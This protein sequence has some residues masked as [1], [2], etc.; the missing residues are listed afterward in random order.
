M[1][2][3]D[4]EKYSR[5]ILFDEV[6][7]QG[8]QRLLESRAVIVGCGALGSF[9]ATALARAG[10]GNMVIIDRDYVEPSNLQRQWL[11]DESDAEQ[12]LPKAAAAARRLAAINSSVQV[13]PCI[14]DLTAAN[15]ERL[16]LPADVILDGCDNFETRYLINDLA[17]KHGI[18]WIYGAAV[19]SYGITMP[20][21]PKRSACL[22]CIFPEPPGGVQPTCDTAGILNSITAAIAALQV[23]DALKIMAGKTDAVQARMLTMDV[24]KGTVRTVSC[25]RADPDC[26][27]CGRRKFQYLAGSRRR[28]ATLC[29]R[30]AVQINERE[31]PLDLAELQATL[32]PL[33]TVRAN[34]YALRF[35]CP[36]HEMTIFADGRAIVKGTDDIGVARGLYARYVGI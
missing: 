20:I 22:A 3:S 12:A 14:A 1:T 24:W 9:H 16:L 35:I 32:E 34:D 30:D 10:V 8:Q 27:V 19:G 21:L 36:P 7:E 28:A 23:A 26:A 17:V 5:Q 4:R 2:D 33:G 18:P 29:G 11:F 25:E 31:R 13:E 15:A 6:G